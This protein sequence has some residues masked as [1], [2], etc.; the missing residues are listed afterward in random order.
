MSGSSR[1][2]AEVP[3]WVT[4]WD[5]RSVS[6]GQPR[7]PRNESAAVRNGGFR[8]PERVREWGGNGRGRGGSGVTSFSMF[9]KQRN[10]SEEGAAHRWEQLIQQERFSSAA[11]TRLRWAHIPTTTHANCASGS[12]S[13]GRCGNL[14]PQQVARTQLVER[15]KTGKAASAPAL[16]QEPS[17]EMSRCI[18]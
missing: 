1:K 12:V 8:C 10:M 2:S 17:A 13:P 5:S 18:H 11:A 9:L 16:L 15:Q 4:H 7:K 6:A 14:P 3:S